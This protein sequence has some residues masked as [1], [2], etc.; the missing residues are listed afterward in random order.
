MFIIILLDVYLKVHLLEQLPDVQYLSTLNVGV[1]PKKYRTSSIFLA[2]F[3]AR[4]HLLLDITPFM[5]ILQEFFFCVFYHVKKLVQNTLFW[6]VFLALFY[7][8]KLPDSC[9]NPWFR[10][11]WVVSGNFFWGQKLPDTRFYS[12][13]DL[14]GATHK[15]KYPWIQ[16]KSK[17]PSA[18][19]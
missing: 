10:W 19:D 18:F 5:A 15:L 14:S 12:W 13:G 8:K 3:H 9:Q 16:W 1:R 7:K 4:M 11:F 17:N 6:R 2:I